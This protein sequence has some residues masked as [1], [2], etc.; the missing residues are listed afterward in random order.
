[1]YIRW[2]LWYFTIDIVISK[3]IEVLIVLY[4]D[5]LVLKA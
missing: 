1:M 2:N 4:I 5:N 3:L